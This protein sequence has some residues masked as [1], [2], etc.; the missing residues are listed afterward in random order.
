LASP[1]WEGGPLLSSLAPKEWFRTVEKGKQGAGTM[2][3]SVA[4][5]RQFYEGHW[6]DQFGAAAPVVRVQLRH[7]PF[8]RGVAFDLD[9][10]T[11]EVYTPLIRIPL[12]KW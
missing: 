3:I 7:K 6:P 9:A 4:K 2:L 8:D 11:G 5:L 1:A 12:E 10:W